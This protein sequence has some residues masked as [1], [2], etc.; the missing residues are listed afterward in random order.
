M[1][2]HDKAMQDDHK[3]YDG[4]KYRPN[5]SPPLIFKILFCGLLVWGLCFMGYF[6]FSGWSSHGEYASI[7]TAKE[8]RL[9]AQTQLAKPG[10]VSTNEERRTTHLAGEGKALFATHCASCHGADAKGGIGPD[11]TRKQFKYG[12]SAP[13]VTRTIVE[14]RPGGMPPFQGQLSK[15]QI[16]GLV[17]YVLS[18]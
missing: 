1:Q 17:K 10:E 8:A 16:E 7:K 14:G 2:H 12:R 6:L 5:D 11:L 9:A 13:E 15:D 18:L 4:I 3:E